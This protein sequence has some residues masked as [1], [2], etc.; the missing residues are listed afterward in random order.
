TSPYQLAG[1][2][3]SGGVYSGTGVSNGMFDPMADGVG[4]HMIHYTYT[5]A[6]GCV[7]VDSQAIVV[8]AQPVVTFAALNPVCLD[9]GSITLTGG[10]PAGGIYY[11]NGITNGVF[12]PMA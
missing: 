7:A 4:S 8:N 5:S 12:D 3:P 2:F 1:G 6:F 9:A 10:S 11:G